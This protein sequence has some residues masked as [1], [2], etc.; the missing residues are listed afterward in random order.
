MAKDFKKWSVK[1]DGV[2]C[3]I[4]AVDEYT[5]LKAAENQL[6][7]LSEIKRLKAIFPDIREELE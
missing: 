2:K 7:L 4:M 5:A 3:F 1:I 6:A